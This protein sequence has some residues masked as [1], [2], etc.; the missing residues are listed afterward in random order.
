MLP[1]YDHLALT[2]VDLF[3]L[4]LYSQVLL[5][6]KQFLLLQIS[7]KAVT[8]QLNMFIQFL[9]NIHSIYNIDVQSEHFG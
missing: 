2:I 9:Y 7:R 5:N 3:H 8:F 1:K 4:A 6:P